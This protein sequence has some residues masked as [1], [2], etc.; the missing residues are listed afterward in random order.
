MIYDPLN[1]L[2]REALANKSNSFNLS[3]YELTYSKFIINDQK[4]IWN[5]ILTKTQKFRGRNCLIEASDIWQRPSHN[6][7]R[8]PRWWAVRPRGSLWRRTQR[9]RPR[10]W[11][12]EIDGLTAWEWKIVE[13]KVDKRDNWW[14][15][16]EVAI[17]SWQNALKVGN[18][19]KTIKLIWEVIWWCEMR[20]RDHKTKAQIIHQRSNGWQ[21]ARNSKDAW[22]DHWKRQRN[23]KVRGRMRRTLNIDYKFESW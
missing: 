18:E 16:K 19:R 23:H 8:K 10:D 1:S 7:I 11:K 13:T 12:S 21:S 5:G 17:S 22:I 2:I 3:G 4:R 14:N 20:N 6:P 9:K 15:W